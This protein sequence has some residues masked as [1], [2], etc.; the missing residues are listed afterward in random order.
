MDEQNTSV[1]AG[2]GGKKRDLV[3]PVSILVA[4]LLVSGALVWSGTQSRANPPAQDAGT[5]GSP[6]NMKPISANDH[7]LGNPNAPVKI[8]EY[9][10]LE[11]PFCKEF[12]ATMHQVLQAYGDKVAWIFRDAPLVQLHPKAAKEAE[13]SEC[14]A[15]LGGN[16]AFWKFVD[17][18][19]AITPSNNGL[20]PAELP[21]IAGDLGLDVTKFNQCLSSGEMRA[22]VSADYQDAVNAGLQGTPYGIVIA[23]SGKKYIIPG[24]LPFEPQLAGQPS[25]KQIIDTALADK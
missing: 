14:A 10:D 1:G 21:K 9:S 20:D 17:R 2:R 7:I 12:Q 4:A 11:C 18:V 16:D 6:A 13:A 5:Q 24:A 8:V 25:V 15:K 22:R 3:L 19:F 23:P